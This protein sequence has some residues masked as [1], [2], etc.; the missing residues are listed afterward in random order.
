MNRKKKEIRIYKGIKPNYPVIVSEFIESIL[1]LQKNK[2]ETVYIFTYHIMAPDEIGELIRYENKCLDK[3]FSKIIKMQ[4][5]YLSEKTSKID[6]FEKIYNELEKFIQKQSKDNVFGYAN[7]RTYNYNKKLLKLLHYIF[8]LY[9]K[10]VFIK[11]Q[12]KDHKTYFKGNGYKELIEFFNCKIGNQNFDLIAIEMLI[13][14]YKNVMG[15]RLKPFVDGYED[16]RKQYIAQKKYLA[17]VLYY[18]VKSLMDVEDTSYYYLM[19]GLAKTY[20]SDIDTFLILFC[21]NLKYLF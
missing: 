3:I 9:T 17:E 5:K 11:K 15:I 4:D 6:A 18:F 2:K 8:T 14:R 21:E 10:D 13:R 12:H 16:L 19:E 1:K 20:E 7:G